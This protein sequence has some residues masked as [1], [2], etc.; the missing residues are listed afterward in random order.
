MLLFRTRNVHVFGFTPGPDPY[1]PAHHTKARRRGSFPAYGIAIRVR[2]PRGGEHWRHARWRIGWRFRP[3]PNKRGEL[4]RG[5][6]MAE[7]DSWLTD[8][9]SKRMSRK[10]FVRFKFGLGGAFDD[11]EGQR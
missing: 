3:G 1:W 6:G 2:D 9:P 11:P 8:G 4:G 5:I 10:I 7:F